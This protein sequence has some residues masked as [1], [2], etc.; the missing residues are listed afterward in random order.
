[1]DLPTSDPIRSLAEEETVLPCRYLPT[2]D[3]VVN[4]QVTWYK[5]KA[6]GTKDQI[7]TAHHTNG[8]TGELAPHSSYR[9]A[10]SYTLHSTQ[11][12]FSWYYKLICQIQLT[13]V[14]WRLFCSLLIELIE[15]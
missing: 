11:Q 10:H 4:V 7:I 12:T 6:D 2:E 1:M 9:S 14:D 3:N 8:Q 15:L 5:E 13:N